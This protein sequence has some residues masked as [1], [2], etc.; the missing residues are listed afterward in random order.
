MLNIALQM[1]YKYYLLSKFD[2]LIDFY[3]NLSEIVDEIK[4]M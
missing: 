3:K 2:T 1:H 4:I